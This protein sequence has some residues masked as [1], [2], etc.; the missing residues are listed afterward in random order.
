MKIFPGF[1]FSWRRAFGLTT[2]AVGMIFSYVLAVAG[3]L[4]L[5]IAIGGWAL[6]PT[7]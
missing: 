7:S 5:V 1:T 4:Y 2:M 6:E 3:F